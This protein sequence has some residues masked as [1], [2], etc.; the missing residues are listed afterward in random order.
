MAYYDD[1]IG[2]S[3]LKLAIKGGAFILISNFA[4]IECELENEFDRQRKK[5]QNYA[6]PKFL[7]TRPASFDVSFVIYPDEERAF[8]RDVVPLLRP[9]GKTGASAPYEIQA[10]APNR[11]GV[12]RVTLEKAK[13]GPASGKTGRLVRFQMHEW[14]PG[15]AKPKA[16][17]TPPPAGIEPINVFRNQS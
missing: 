5:G 8:W 9:K 16:Q 7:G 2:E 3:T 12:K 6:R 11:L 13:I 15:P 1:P 17:A 10:A 14:T 4:E